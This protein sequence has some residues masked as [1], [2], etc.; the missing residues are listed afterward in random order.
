VQAS[1]SDGT[2]IDT[3]VS[4]SNVNGFLLPVTMK[5]DINEPHLALSAS[6][7]FKDYAFTSEVQ[8][9]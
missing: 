2:T 4:N 1:Y 7:D 6:A 8:L 9:K 3:H 5:A